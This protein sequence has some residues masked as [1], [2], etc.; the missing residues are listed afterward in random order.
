LSVTEEVAAETSN[1]ST[2]EDL[3]AKV[4][5][6]GN[7]GGKFMVEVGVEGSLRR[8][9]PRSTIS[10]NPAFTRGIT[11]RENSQDLALFASST[12]ALN[13]KTMVEIGI[14]TQHYFLPGENGHYNY[15]EP[16][17]NLSYRPSEKD[18]VTAS[19]SLMSQG[20]HMISNN[21]IGIPTN[22]WV[23]ANDRVPPSIGRQI[24]V[25]YGRTKNKQK[26]ALEIYYKTADQIIDPLPGIGF[27]QSATNNWEED[28][29]QGGENKIYGLE[30]L[31][32][33][34]GE[35]LFGWLAYNLSW[36]QIRY[37][38]VNRGEWYFRQFDRRHDLSLV[39]GYRLN[40]KWQIIGNFVLNSGYRLTL[41]EAIRYDGISGAVV[42]VY[43]ERYNATTPLY[44]RMDVTFRRT[45][46]RY[47]DKK[48][49]LSL[50]CYNVYGRQNPTYVLAQQSSGID[51][52]P[53]ALGY[54]PESISNDLKLFSLFT[55]IPFVG[56]EITF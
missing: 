38:E 8:V 37:D 44:H 29:S 42:P 23:T 27:F 24:S 7:W 32:K 30:F 49:T 26:I 15:P 3:N 54:L 1:T 14:R 18:K 46:E 21:F 45:I 43:T 4:A 39:A 56:Y 17:V 5:L 22:L 36:N 20:L 53:S 35:R 13:R 52:D 51:T 50:G 12:F 48:R 28:I 2:I 11:L 10:S 25:G 47:S 9:T 41:P 6:R 40:K 34:S 31:Y 16:R 33:K 19:F 55:F